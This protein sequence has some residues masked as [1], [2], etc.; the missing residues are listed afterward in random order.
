MSRIGQL[1]IPLPEGVTVD[2]Q[3]SE[4][5]VK[6]PKGEL[7]RS[8]HPAMSIALKDGSLVVSRPS[9]QKIYRALHGLT[10]SLLANMVEGVEKGFEKS[11]EI[12]GVGYRV[13]KTGDNLVLQVGYTH[14]VEISPPLG[15]SLL[16]EGPNRIKVS[17]IDKEV[18]GEVAARI[19]R[20]HPPDAYKGKGIR[21][22][23]ER[24]RLKPG[25]A[26]RAIGKK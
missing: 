6:G 11:L 18:V 24:V 15:I 1:P 8:F 17:G 13:Q 4:V 12:V 26:G 9:D 7:H 19:R 14:P 20:V 23:G 5:I 22:L 10:R 3:G 21:Y 25:K 16:A 2:I